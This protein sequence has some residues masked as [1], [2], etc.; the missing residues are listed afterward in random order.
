MVII[1][2][3][4]TITTSFYLAAAAAAANSLQSR[5]TLFDPIDGIPPGSS[6]HGRTLAFSRQEYWSGVPSPSLHFI[7]ITPLK[8]LFPATVTF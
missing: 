6:I 2:L 7:L 1:G 4:P 5:P 3:G 8:T